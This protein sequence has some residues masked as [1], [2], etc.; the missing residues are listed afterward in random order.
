MAKPLRKITGREHLEHNK[1]LI[2][3]RL[4]G[5]NETKTLAGYNTETPPAGMGPKEEGGKEFVRKHTISKIADRNGNGD[6]VFNASNMSS[7]RDNVNHGYKPGEDQK[8][9]E[10]TEISEE[11]FVLIEKAMSEAQRKLMAMALAYKRG[12]MEDASPAVKKLA[13]SMTIKQLEDFA[14]TKHKGLPEKVYETADTPIQNS[15]G[16]SASNATKKRKVPPNKGAL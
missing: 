13:K 7:H 15:P 2:D 10:E 9:Y 11:K 16:I 8:V 4:E 6:E 1:N 12:E 14:E 5:S 3:K